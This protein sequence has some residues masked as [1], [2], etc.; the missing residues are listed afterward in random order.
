MLRVYV[1][2]CKE[3]Q[4]EDIFNERIGNIP[5]VRIEKCLK[6]KTMEGKS[7]SLGASLALSEAL[8]ELGFS[9]AEIRNADILVSEHGKPY[10][11]N[12]FFNLSHTVDMAVCAVSD[13]EI[14]VD[15]EK[16]RDFNLNIVKRFFCESEYRYLMSIKD[17][18]EKMQNE[19]F[20]LWTLKESYIKAN[21]KGL[22]IGLDSFEFD[23]GSGE[24]RSRLIKSPD[25]TEWFFNEIKDFALHKIAICT[26]KNIKTDSIITVDCSC[27]D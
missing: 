13:C 24:L 23:T 16:I 4:S 1:V 11:N 25:N 15:V 5:F 6:H 22:F 17:N 8:K 26:E 12:V 10:I 19:F 20:R 14:G 7:Q 18:K 21:A 3:L 9:K 27:L 2:N